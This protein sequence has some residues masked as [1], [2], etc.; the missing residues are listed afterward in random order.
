MKLREFQK[1]LKK[2]KIMGA[3]FVHPDPTIRYFTQKEFSNALLVVTSRK[4]ILF[5]TALDKKPSIPGI[6]VKELLK[7]WEKILPSQRT[8]KIGIHKKEISVHFSDKLHKTFKGAKFVDVSSFVYT[9]R[10]QKTPKEIIAIRHAC[11]ITDA[12]FRE[13]I[14]ELKKRTLRTERDVALF[15]DTQIRKK[16]AEPAFP[17]I[18]AIGKNAAIPHHTPST[19]PITKGFLLLDFGARYNGYCSDMSRTVFIGTITHIEKKHYQQLLCCQE[20]SIN[21]IDTCATFHELDTFARNELNTNAQYFVHS[22]GHG[23]GLEIHEPPVYS[24]KHAKI[25]KNMVFTVEPGIYFPQ[26]YGLRIEDTIIFTGKAHILTTSPK[27]LIC[28]PCKK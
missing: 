20:K 22:L 13:V 27:R 19:T 14:T 25:N 18:V 1:Y 4:A 6:E 12:V 28:I 17:S 23:L 21:H 5:I 9:L 16:G 11:A 3:I 8:S 24:D 15:I 7:E 10:Q 2:Q 26:K